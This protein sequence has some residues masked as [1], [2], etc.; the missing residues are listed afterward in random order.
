MTLK[1]WVHDPYI[2]G[3]DPIFEGSWTL[4]VEVV[5]FLGRLNTKCLQIT[6]RSACFL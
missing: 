1:K 2:L 4:Q 6:P 3:N 5:G